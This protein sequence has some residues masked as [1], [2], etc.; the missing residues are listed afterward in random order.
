[1]EQRLSFG[2]VAALY[3]RT[4]PSYPA[5]IG[6]RNCARFGDAVSFELE[7]ALGF[8]APEYRR[9]EW[10]AT[11]ATAQYVDVTRTQSDHIELEPDVRERLLAAVGNVIDEAGGSFTLPF[12]SQLWLA[13]AV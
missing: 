6:R 3:D 7:A 1:M 10:A 12:E 9:Y 5:A 13:R 8:A 4:R 11:V 2:S